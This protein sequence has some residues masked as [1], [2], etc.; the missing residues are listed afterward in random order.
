MA[1]IKLLLALIIATL[2]LV[3][4]VS[5]SSEYSYRYFDNEG[6]VHLGNSIPPE[7]LANGYEI[8]NERGRVVDV[9]LPK[10]VRDQQTADLL[11][12]AEAQRKLE[13]QYAKDEALLRYYSKPEDVIRVR[14]RKLAEFDNFVAIQQGSIEANKQKVVKLQRQAADIERSGRKVSDEILETLATLDEKIKESEALIEAKL[15]EKE[16]L[17]N[18]FQADI[19]R[20]EFLL[21]NLK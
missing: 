19:D 5:W 6:F 21:S 14:D 16:Q 4:G 13:V 18:A 15:I 20:L 7:Y 2:S 10:K 11:A 12:K 8:L 17:N 3:T 9:I 1:R